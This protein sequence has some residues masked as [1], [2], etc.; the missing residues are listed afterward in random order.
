VFAEIYSAGYGDDRR[1]EEYVREALELSDGMDIPREKAVSLRILSEIHLKRGEWRQSEKTAL[2]ALAADD[3]EPAN[4]FALYGILSKSY[5]H[6]GN[7]A[8]SAEYFDKYD[9]L[10][11]V[12][13]NRHYQSSIREME[14]KY[15]TEKKD[16]EIERQQNLI[17]RHHIQRILWIGGIA[18]CAV[19]LALLWYMLRLRTR[20]NHA[21]SEMNATK[22]KFV[23]IIS[24]DLKNPAVSQRDAL[25]LLV[26]NARLW[27]ADTL[28]D[29]YTGLLKSAEG[30]VELIYSLLD[31]ARLQTGR[32]T[33][34]PDTFP[35][36][37]LLPDLPLIRKMAESKGITLHINLPGDALITGDSN[38]LATVVRN[39][40]TNAVK[41]TAS[42]GVVT[43]EIIENG[44]LRMENGAVNS[45]ASGKGS[46]I[47]NSQL[48]TLNSEKRYTVSVSDTG[49]G[50]SR[51]Q[52]GKLFHID[53]AHSRKGTA[54]EEGSGLGLIVCREMLAKH[55]AMLHV[56][57]EEGKGSR[58]WFEVGNEYRV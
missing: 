29:Y 33:C 48:S 32:M 36:A 56:E 54:G 15:E 24:H 2:E 34:T 22:D 49:I 16:M 7:A 55:G 37:E 46:A 47:L 11:S 14:V 58:F 12:W 27:N 42:G 28:T 43:L 21:L 10:K 20:R 8:L 52:T 5:A 25:R 31:W 13:S 9:A 3:S 51:E 6:Q 50:M 35:L 30:Q 39:L 19:I 45:T 44:E 4:T 26:R 40:L 57:S 18:L 38:M 17:A 23:S 41:Y 53:I 1:A